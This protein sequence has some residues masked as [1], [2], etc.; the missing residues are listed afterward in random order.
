M[1]IDSLLGKIFKHHSSTSTDSSSR[2]ES[3]LAGRPRNTLINCLLPLHHQESLLAMH[4]ASRDI[5]PEMSRAKLGPMMLLRLDHNLLKIE[6]RQLR[7]A[8]LLM[9]ENRGN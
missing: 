6:K 4:V 9:A 1:M 3:F 7:N 2:M 8:K 5:S